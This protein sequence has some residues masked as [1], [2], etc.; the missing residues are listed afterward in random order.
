M[1]GGVLQCRLQTPTLTVTV[2]DAV[3]HVAAVDAFVAVWSV[4]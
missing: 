4:S 2:L 3:V 1:K